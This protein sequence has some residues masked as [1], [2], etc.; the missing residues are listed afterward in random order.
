[1]VGL[2]QMHPWGKFLSNTVL[3]CKMVENTWLALD[4]FKERVFF[5]C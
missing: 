2:K 1:M 5:T 4:I 3:F